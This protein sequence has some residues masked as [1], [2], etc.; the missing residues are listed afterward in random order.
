MAT[1]TRNSQRQFL[2][3]ERFTR[4]ETLGTADPKERR[5]PRFHMLQL[6]S[7]IVF[8][9]VHKTLEKAQTLLPSDR[10]VPP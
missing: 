9:Y 8:T 5:T 6:C 7:Q 2:L 1:N 10:V 3:C 4:Q